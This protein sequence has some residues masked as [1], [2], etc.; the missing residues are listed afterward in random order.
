[1]IL[2]AAAS[3]CGVCLNRSIHRFA[4]YPDMIPMFQELQK[5]DIVQILITMQNYKYFL[6]F[7][8]LCKKILPPAFFPCD[9]PV[10]FSSF[11]AVELGFYLC[12]AL[13][14]FGFYCACHL[15]LKLGIRHLIQFQRLLLFP[16]L[17]CGGY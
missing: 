1:M 12:G 2:Y 9:R 15:L 4:P 8:N 5:H 10:R 14:V 13:I 16:C 7:K 11:T 3:L 6:I 17:L